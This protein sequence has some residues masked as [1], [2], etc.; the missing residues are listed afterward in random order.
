MPCII[1]IFSIDLGVP[2][3]LMD[4]N[5]QLI[6][7]TRV[8]VAWNEPSSTPTVTFV[9]VTYC[10]KS[11]PNCR[12]NITCHPTNPCTID[13]LMPNTTYDFSV[14]PN[15]NCGAGNASS[16]TVGTFSTGEFTFGL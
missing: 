9:T 2:P 5:V 11:S 13:G 12:E 6:N 8:E 3:Q 10:P 15:N 14:T 7:V 1:I 4:V 16:K